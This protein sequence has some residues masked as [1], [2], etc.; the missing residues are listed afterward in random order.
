MSRIL[1]PPSGISPGRTLPAYLAAQNALIAG[2]QA[3]GVPVLRILH[4]DGPETP[5]NLASQARHVRPFDGLAEFRDA[6]ATLTNSHSALVGTGLTSGST[7][8]GI[9]HLIASGIRTEQ[10]AEIHHTPRQRPGMDRDFVPGMPP[11]IRDMAQPDGNAA[12][13][14]PHQGRAPPPCCRPL[15]HCYARSRKPLAAAAP[16]AHDT[17]VTSTRRP[18][19]SMW[20]LPCRLAAGPLAG[21]AEALHGQPGTAGAGPAR[22]LLCTFVSPT[23]RWRP[24][25]VIT[26]TGW[27]RCLPG[28]P[29]PAWVVLVGMPGPTIGVRKTMR[30]APCCTGCAAPAAGQRRLELVTV[31]RRPAGSSTLGSLGG[32]PPLHHQHLMNWPGGATLRRGSQLRV[33]GRWPLAQQR[34]RDEVHRPAAPTALRRPAGLMWRLQAAQTMVVALR[35]V[36]TTRSLSATTATTRTPRCT[37]C[38]DDGPTAPGRLER[39]NHGRRGATFAPA[40]DTPVSGACGHC[41]SAVPA[42]HPAVLRL[43]PPCTRAAASPR[44]QRWQVLVSD[45]PAA[46]GLASVRTQRYAIRG[47]RAILV[48][49]CATIRSAAQPGLF[50]IGVPQATLVRHSN[51]SRRHCIDHPSSHTCPPRRAALDK[52]IEIAK[53]RQEPMLIV[54]PAPAANRKT[55]RWHPG[56]KS[57]KLNRSSR[58][59]ASRANSSSLSVAR[60]PEEIN[61]LVETRDISVLIIGLQSC[62]AVG[63]L[64]LGSVAQ[65]LLMTVP[66]PVLCVKAANA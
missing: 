33:R 15:R 23:P 63:K 29:A 49:T 44:R 53:R 25:R 1:P 59:K 35:R 20:S 50:R 2:C 42:L 26:L 52:G 22:A 28:F 65:E 39:S 7:C 41:P 27:R 3:R 16:Q 8:H 4:S 31:C 64:I 21:P 13:R 6:A 36:P 19:P 11:L 56:S 38:S 10:C 58:H 62:T 30:P 43:R 45:T 12:D 14:R 51:P 48:T 5:D 46:P 9:T 37:A 60:A 18:L 61:D 17:T 54:T 40:P 34:W 32:V 55:P 57:N 66:C 47:V 24:R